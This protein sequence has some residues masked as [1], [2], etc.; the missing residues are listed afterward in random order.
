MGTN[1]DCSDLDKQR[2]PS[3]PH[4]HD[5]EYAPIRNRYVPPWLSFKLEGAFLAR[6]NA[7][8]TRAKA[9]RG[10]RWR[11]RLDEVLTLGRI[12]GGLTVAYKYDRVRS[13]WSRSMRAKK[14]QKAL[15][16]KLANQGEMLVEY[17]AEI[18]RRGGLAKARRR[19]EVALDTMPPEQHLIF[20]HQQAVLSGRR[21]TTR[22]KSW[23]EL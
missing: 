19:R 12:L 9:R 21:R 2:P 5:P 16:M 22:A 17:F 10:G 15:Q 1:S 6:L 11:S 8:L 14:G 3:S 20:D 23:L 7:A 4:W 18:G 13:A